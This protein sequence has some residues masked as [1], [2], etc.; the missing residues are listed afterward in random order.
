MT[1]RRGWIIL[2]ALKLL[3]MTLGCGSGTGIE[4]ELE[5]KPEFEYTVKDNDLLSE[6]ETRR[7]NA[8]LEGNRENLKGCWLA[9][10]TWA[11][12]SER[13][14][15]CVTFLPRELREKP[16][17]WQVSVDLG[18]RPDG[19]Q[20]IRLDAAVEKET[21]CF[22]PPDSLT[23]PRRKQLL[24]KATLAGK[25]RLALEGD[26]RLPRSL[27]HVNAMLV[28][29]ATHIGGVDEIYRVLEGRLLP[30]KQ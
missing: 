12:P 2:A 10:G 4:P 30:E 6:E 1:L 11:S 18:G 21:I 20:G 22:Y 25:D 16:S 24:G 27:V 3:A 9:A 19:F 23:G 17:A 14:V 26:F 13:Q 7:K 8:A 28:R 15:L 29:T 5:D